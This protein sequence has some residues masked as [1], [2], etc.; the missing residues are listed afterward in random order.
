MNSTDGNQ[1]RVGVEIEFAGMTATEAAE[2][3]VSVEEVGGDVVASTP[4]ATKIK[5]G[6]LDGAN[7]ELDYRY[8]NTPPEGEENI[9]D[10][11][12]EAFKTRDI[13]A[14]AASYLWPVEL[15][16]PPIPEAKL[17]IIES[18]IDALRRAGAMGT[19]ESPFY[20]YGLHLNCELDPPDPDRAV[21]VGTAF[22]FAE[23]WLRWRV[24]PDLSR[25]ATPYVDPYPPMFTFALNNRLTTRKLDLRGFIELYG[26]WCPTRNHALDMWPLLGWLDPDTANSASFKKIKRPRPAFHYRLPDCDLSD[27]EWTPRTDLTLWRRIE[28]IADDPTL[29]EAAR[30][31]WTKRMFMQ[32]SVFQYRR[33]FE[34][35]TE[36]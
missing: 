3:I 18:A 31:A 2:T 33:R 8:A 35:M 17:H 26:L 28:Q 5:G 29:F 22:A 10:E 12:I 23:E 11:M 15:S 9:V 24:G 14:E 6:A 7:I 20:A 13:T 25:R 4:Y 21:R 30:E 16:A 1:R 34:E 36:A 32:I 19:R 27:P